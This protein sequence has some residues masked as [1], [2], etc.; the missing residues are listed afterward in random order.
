MPSKAT[1][2]I[3]QGDDYF[4]VV[5]VTNGT[6]TP[7]DLTGYEAQA[8]IRLSI[9]DKAADVIVEIAT[10][11]EG[12][13]IFLSIPAAQTVPLSGTYAWDLQLTRPDGTI[14]TILAGGVVVTGEVTREPQLFREAL[15]RPGVPRQVEGR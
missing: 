8:Q 4:A 13:Q 7:P 5:T 1:L 15:V 14:V 10:Q 2:A 6:P 11:I 3:Y 12:N 9:A